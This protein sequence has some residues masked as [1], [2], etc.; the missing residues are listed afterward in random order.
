MNKTFENNRRVRGR[1]K[2]KRLTVS[3]VVALLV[4][5]LILLTGG[6]IFLVP[7]AERDDGR[8]LEITDFI[9]DEES[10]DSD[11]KD[12]KAYSVKS[13][14]TDR[15]KVKR[16]TYGAPPSITP[17]ATPVS[18]P[19]EQTTHTEADNGEIAVN[20]EVS[21][22]LISKAVNKNL[23]EIYVRPDNRR[24]GNDGDYRGT[25]DE[26]DFSVQQPQD[27]YISYIQKFRSKVQN[28]WRPNLV[29]AP[30]IQASNDITIV[31]LINIRNNGEIGSIEISKPSGFAAFDREA[32][33][34]VRTAAPYSPFP[35]SWEGQPSY[36]F[37]FGFKFI[38]SGSM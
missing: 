33:R 36:T 27:K 12:A 9:P 15:N 25:S 38:G 1:H 29:F 11:V 23:R 26:N 30:G 35:A 37:S 24:P 14:S 6:K 20:T 3:L 34:S 32:V 5:L 2:R 8:L 28:V 13:Y 16:G 21:E 10:P 19:K 18:Q 22:R 17:V 31:L 4:H 7:V